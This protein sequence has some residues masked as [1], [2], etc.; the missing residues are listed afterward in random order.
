MRFRVRTWV[1]TVPRIGVGAPRLRFPSLSSPFESM[2]R[3]CAPPSFRVK[4]GGGGGIRRHR[5]RSRR[6]GIDTWV[7]SKTL[8]LAK[9][10]RKKENDCQ[11]NSRYRVVALSL[12]LVVTRRAD[13]HVGHRPRRSPFVALLVRG[14]LPPGDCLF[15]FFSPLLRAR[16]L[17]L[18][19]LLFYRAFPSGGSHAASS[20]DLRGSC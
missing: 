8:P 7:R 11:T 18:L 20:L 1:K 16:A 17:L 9:K 12:L 4:R 5:R 15:T 14:L 19:L 13:A 2:G 3:S 6:L 10:E